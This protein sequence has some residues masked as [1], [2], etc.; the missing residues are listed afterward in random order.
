MVLANPA[1]PNGI[2]W[3]SAGGATYPAFCDM[4]GGGWELVL[5]TAHNSTT[6]G[7]Y[8]P[9]WENNDLLNSGRHDRRGH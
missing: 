6:F 4:L 3:L 2:Y 8:S 9:L 5:S 1:L 7:F